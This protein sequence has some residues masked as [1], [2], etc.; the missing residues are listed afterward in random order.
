MPTF[1][2]LLTKYVTRAGIGDA[3]L[4]RRIRISRLTLT[5]WKEGVTSRPRHREDVVRCAD[6]LRLTSDE[7][8]ELLTAAGFSP[9]EPPDA[10]AAAVTV[11]S[12]EGAAE[13]PIVTPHRLSRTL[14]V[15]GAAVLVV[16]AALGYFFLFRPEGQPDFPVAADGESVILMAPFVNYTGGQQGFNIQGRLTDEVER[17]V[18]T[19]GLANVRVVEWTDPISTETEAAAAA[20]KS[21]ADMVIWGEYDSGRAMANFTVPSQPQGQGGYNPQVVDISLSPADLPTS[22]NEALTGEVRTV[23]LMVLGQLYLERDEHDLA[24]AALSEAMS[25]QP[26]NP[27][28]LAGIKFRLG[29]AYMGGTYADLDE[30]VWLF[31]QVLAVRPRS[32]D[33]LNNRALAYLE[34]DREGD[35]ALAV[36]DLTR[37]LGLEPRSA[38]TYLNR[39]VAHLRHG[40]RHNLSR[41]I[42]DFERA[43]E[44]DPE[45]SRAYVNRASA[46]L[47]RG[48]ERDLERTFDDVD[49]A[50][51]IDPKLAIAYVN[52][53]NAYLQRGEN[54]DLGRAGEEYA[55]AIELEPK[56]ATA[57]YNRVLVLSALLGPSEDWT[58]STDDLL[59]AQELEPRN[60]AFNNTLCWQLG[61]QRRPDEAL[62]YCNV[63]LE[64]RPEGLVLD[65]L[66]LVYAVMGEYDEAVT[67]FESFLTWVGTSQKDACRSHYQ[68]SRV[69]WI[70][71][72]KAGVDPFNAE[73]LR[74]LRIR[75]AP[76]SAVDI[77]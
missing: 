61:V 45:Y 43:I 67:N 74:E 30:A 44:L 39:G 23:A 71:D 56:S 58:D 51:S 28:T 5:R 49:K 22:I 24:K 62:P 64:E 33:T 36:D 52:R 66:G 77:C 18:S 68:P 41:S 50:L 48:D 60:F 8:D 31:T 15:S 17:A 63:A 46:Y 72:L 59:H 53:G 34:R 38:G 1:A 69:T 2:E 25:Q 9:D 4:A 21:R 20:L 54:E 6:V 35:V 11:D 40:D 12:T 55:R 70:N 7:R 19:A 37:A 27:D 3:E 76:P 73:L 57:Y 16:V 47:Q 29:L 10:P 75:P 65:S 14:V 13:P 42:A 32:V 26:V